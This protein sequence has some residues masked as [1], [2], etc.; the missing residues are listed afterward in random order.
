MIHIKIKK[1]ELIE[2]K[3]DRSFSYDLE[4][5]NFIKEVILTSMKL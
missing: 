5:K 4:E 2:V 1:G 3:T